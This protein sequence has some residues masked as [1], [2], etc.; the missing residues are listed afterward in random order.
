VPLRA[1]QNARI[2]APTGEFDGALIYD[3]IS[4]RITAVLNQEAAESCSCLPKETLDAQGAYLVPGGI[5]GHVHF[6]GFGDIPIAD[7]F[8]QG[9]RAAL[10][11]GTTTLVDFCE[12]KPGESAAHCIA[13]RK[14]EAQISAA[15]YLFHFVMTEDY[16]SLLKEIDT[17]YA[18][19]I[20]SF[21]LFTTY[22][23][24]SLSID[25]ILE[26]FRFFSMRGEHPPF[27]IHAEEPEEIAHLISLN[28]RESMNMH[29]LAETR[30]ERTEVNMVRALH[31]AAR[32]AG[33]KICIAH[34][35]TSGAVLEKQR[36][37]DDP[38]F[39][40]ETCPHYLAFTDKKLS[41]NDGALYTTT[42]PLRSKE[43]QLVLWKGIAS[44]SIA[45]LST[46]HCPYNLREKLGRSFTE[47][48]CGVDGVSSRMLF[49]FSEGVMKRGISMRHFVELTSENSAKFY[50]LFPKKGCILPGS[51]ADLVLLKPSSPTPWNLKLCEGNID[52]TIYEGM[53]FQGKIT[54][55]IRRG[56]TVY[57]GKKLEVSKG[58]GLYIPTAF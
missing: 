55:V 1:I 34:T 13:V 11:G 21:K 7:D 31:V 43:N 10:S 36:C 29:L 6:G 50:G 27:L 41:G 14:E 57:D 2:I 40:L 20:G 24:T 16:H 8:Y 53:Q 18:E 28:N 44:G 19:G 56:E 45:M 49:L 26:I 12:P 22:P 42:P 35:T 37:P 54:T 30:P 58:S 52:Y 23:N 15:D 4:G 33:A 9:S 51:D 25:D 3:D 47:V 17:V 48:P 38:N 5:D 39:I 32:E 46:D